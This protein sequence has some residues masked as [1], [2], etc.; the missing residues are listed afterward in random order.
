MD[1]LDENGAKQQFRNY[2]MNP[3]VVNGA[4]KGFSM[5]AG[6]FQAMQDV[7]NNYGQAVQEFRVYL[8]RVNGTN[9]LAMMV[10][11]VKNQVEMTDHIAS[12][13]LTLTKTGPCPPNCD[14]ASQIIN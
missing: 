11:G 7:M 10:V 3:V 9:D 1:I 4:I 8:G 6:I 13:T 5:E 14:R 12:V 2:S